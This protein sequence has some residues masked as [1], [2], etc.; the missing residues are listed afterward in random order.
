MPFL[1]L[2]FATIGA[3]VSSGGFIPPRSGDPLDHLLPLVGG[4][5]VCTS[6][7][8]TEP[9]HRQTFRWESIL[10]GH[11]IRE[12]MEI[13]EIGFSREALF[14]W[15]QE[16]SRV[17]S[18]TMTNNGFLGHAT[19]SWEEDRIV[20]LGRILGPDGGSMEQKESLELLSSGILRAVSY[21][22]TASGWR[23]RHVLEYER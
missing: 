1:F 7:D 20:I 8:G 21:E 3:L 10:D 16:R 9:R 19:I 6:W 22:P 23:E 17:A 11:G 12:T 13:R 18:L 15:D 14:Y 4:T 5:W 2:T